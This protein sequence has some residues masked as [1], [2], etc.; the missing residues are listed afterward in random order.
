MKK[1]LSACC[2]FLIAGLTQAQKAAVK[3]WPNT[4]WTAAFMTEGASASS[5][6][7]FVL[8]PD[9]RLQTFAPGEEPKPFP[10]IEHVIAISAGTFHMLALRSDGTVWAWGRN[11]DR[12]LGNEPLSRE[13]KGSSTPVQVSGVEH[14]VAI[15]AFGANSY[16]LLADGT[17]WAWGYGNNGMTG[18]GEKLTG[19][20][21]SANWSARKLPVQ[22]AGISHAIAVAGPMALLADG[23]VV[24]WGDGYWGQLGNGSNT[25]SA[26]P[27]KVKGL[28]NVTAISTREHGALALLKDGTVWSWGQNAKGQLGNGNQ[29][30]A[31]NDQSNLP[32]QVK[33]LADVVAIDAHAVCLA[34]LKNGTVKAWGWGAVGGMGSGRAGTNDVNASP[35]KVP[36]EGHTIAI[37]AG[38]GYGLALQDD[39]TVVGWGA[40]MVATGVYRQTWTPVKIIHIELRKNRM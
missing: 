15:S 35:L 33:G 22:V 18:D 4:N 25:A 40:H 20:M 27:V 32:V 28:A 38:N 19:A 6:R 37:K 14:A 34:L 2:L 7:H 8:L 21:T 39:G 12:Q 11:D 26:M 29:R 31:D 9:G 5:F 10:G 36:L 3:N 1:F 16:A 17:V 24:A 13:G 23:T 30:I